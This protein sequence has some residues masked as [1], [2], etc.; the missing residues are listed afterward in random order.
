MEFDS[1]IKKVV[2]RTKNCPPDGRLWI[3]TRF[4][5]G[6][7]RLSGEIGIMKELAISRVI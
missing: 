4:A 7:E 5:R 3:T 6:L 2:L 1:A